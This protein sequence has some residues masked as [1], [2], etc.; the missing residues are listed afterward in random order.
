MADLTSRLSGL[1]PE[2]RALLERRLRAGAT[3]V[4]PTGAEPLAVIGIGCRFPGAVRDH[5]SLWQLLLDG[6]DAVSE[7]PRERWN[8]DEL[9]DA[10]PTASGRTNTRWGGFLNTKDNLES[11]DDQFFRISPREAERMDP[12]QRLL[13]ETSWEALEHAGLPPDAL[14]GQA[15]GVFV[16]IHS[17]S[18]DYY[19]RQASDLPPIDAYTSTGVAH[20]IVANR[21]S[22]I[23]DLRG[24][25]LAVDTACSSSLVAVH[26]ACQ[27]LRHRESDVALAGG[28]NLILTPEA[29]VAFSKLQMMAG[30]GRCK[31]FDKRADGFVRGE[32]CGVVVLKRLS[33]AQR[34]GDPV[35][36]VIRGSAVNQDGATNGLTAPNGLAQQAVIRDALKNAGVAPGTVSYIET[37]GTGTALGDPIEVEAISAVLEVETSP[38]P[39]VLG[40]LKTNIGHL[41]AAAGIAGLIK[42]VLCLK[43]RHIPRNL[44]FESINPHIRL[45][46]TRLRLPTENRSWDVPEGTPRLAGVSSFGFGGT[47]AHIVLEEAME[48]SVAPERAPVGPFV[49]PLSARTEQ[50]LNSSIEAWKTFLAAPERTG[51]SLADITYSASCRRTHHPLRRAVVGETRQEL[52]DALNGLAKTGPAPDDKN[53]GPVFVYSGQGPQ[54]PGMGQGLYETEPVFRTALDRCDAEFRRHATWSLLDEL[55]APDGKSRLHRTDIAQP[56]L[57]AVQMGLTELFRAWGIEPDAVVGHSIGEVAAAWASGAIGFEDAARLVVGRGRLMHAAHGQGRMLAVELPPDVLTGHL[58]ALPGRLVIAAINSPT[59][60]VVSGDHD[61]V[62][63]LEQRLAADGIR[64]KTVNADYAFHSHQVETAAEQ[65][66]TT[67]SDLTP[68]VPRVTLVSSVTG[69]PIKDAGCTSAY[70]ARNVRQPVRF[71][72]AIR[73][74]ISDGRRMF[75]EVGPHPVLTSMIAACGVTYADNDV[76]VV[77]TLRRGQVER[78]AALTALGRLYEIGGRVNWTNVQGSAR[79]VALPSYP[80]D[81]R[82]HWIEQPKPAASEPRGIDHSPSNDIYDVRW[83]VRGRLAS[84][85]ARQSPAYINDP[86]MIARRLGEWRRRFPETPASST[87]E[88]E[89]ISRLFAARALRALSGGHDDRIERTRLSEAV[90]LPRAVRLLARL[91]RTLESAG[92]MR[93]TSDGWQVSAPSD[94][95]VVLLQRLIATD[96]SSAPVARLLGHCGPRLADALAGTIEPLSLL[97]S[98]DPAVSAERIYTDS[99]FARSGNALVAQ[100]VA[101][102]VEHLPPE[103]AIRILEIGAGTGSTTAELIDL[104][105]E[106]RAEYIFTDVSSGFLQRARG[107]FS[108]QHP[109]RYA[110][111]DVE[112]SL[113]DQGFSPGQ[114]DI[115]VAANVLHTTADLRGT[116]AR[117]HRLLAPQGLLILLEGASPRGWV[118]LT[119]GLTEGWWKFTDTDRRRD[120]PLVSGQ[121]WCEA[122]AQ[123]GFSHCETVAVSNAPEHSLFEQSIV[124]ARAG[125]T[126]ERTATRPSPAAS[127]RDFASSTWCLFAD[128]TGVSSNL[129]RHLAQRGDRV[130]VVK[131]GA[132]FERIGDHTSIRFDDF[133]D[134]DALVT[135]LP[136]GADQLL[137]CVYLWPLDAEP[138]PADSNWDAAQSVACGGLINFIAALQRSGRSFNGGLWVVTRGAQAAQSGQISLSQTPL[139]GI[140]RGI[141]VERPELW[142]GLIDLDHAGSLDHV[143]TSMLE[144]F[145]APDGE[146]QIALRGSERFVPRLV[147][148]Q[149]QTVGRV[150]L[151]RD[152]SYFIT[153]G[154]G[155]LGLQLARWMAAAGAGWIVLG[156]RRGSAGAPSHVLETVRSIEKLGAV[157][158]ITTVDAGEMS[159]LRA[160]MDSFGRERPRLGG[161][162]H[163]AGVVETQAIES[164]P[165]DALSRVMRPKV[166]GAWNLHRLSQEHTPD[167]FVMFSSAA[168]VWGAAGMA[169]YAAANHFLDALARYRTGSGLPA[170]CLNWGWWEGGGTTQE[171]HD[172]YAQIGLESMPSVSAL[173]ALEAVLGSGRSH[174]TI[175]RVEWSRFSAVYQARRARPLLEY[176]NDVAD[177]SRRDDGAATVTSIDLIARLRNA[178]DHDKLPQLASH[179]RAE[180]ARV[181]GLPSGSRIED[182]EGFFELGMDSI[183]TVELRSRLQEGLGCHLP[184]TVA[185]EYPN[186]LALAG[187]I[188]GELG[189]QAAASAND[190]Q[191]ADSKMDELSGRSADE[192]AALLDQA[193]VDSLDVESRGER[194]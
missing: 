40:A 98:D 103:R 23:L 85:I 94:D 26:L 15:V 100:A 95:P 164:L 71:S 159:S 11:F 6:V 113:D 134:F 28:V 153:G 33:D 192:L 151:R 111:L 56:A 140:G 41:E 180:V 59:S 53:D 187:F 105:P 10:N 66:A 78:Y 22:Y 19:W 70:W 125:S 27:S 132:T 82:T 64:C 76:V 109:I 107:K 72:D 123:V 57:F 115:I 194:N 38:V 178:A 60:S 114:V 99:L 129:Q 36:A 150:N 44:H 179:V 190:S 173:A 7:I 126:A 142:G 182:A 122:L 86:A 108:G 104:L 157:V 133:S 51:I 91:A 165:L 21:V 152:R 149:P 17:L 52:I 138:I 110:T 189:L 46:G 42:A 79:A 45:E 191:A 176:I 35:L 166:T 127:G 128:E 170:T 88:L 63:A 102:A 168:S 144:E 163:A 119:F 30:N 146:D 101:A 184:V 29:T 154:T 135:G 43:H 54:W 97:F 92:W 148:V 24:P 181:L 75:L 93:P 160:V 65:L 158:D 73:T 1:S 143:V 136:L 141:S 67:I 89:R 124:L 25:S 48:V 131:N 55:R 188:A 130:I 193:I 16:G 32:G 49:L 171:Q 12:Q 84:S 20:S 5:A 13:L 112:R 3:S 147:R 9:Y 4:Q 90:T 185:F 121:G 61:A 145:E 18:T 96:A 74:L 58:R 47:N 68:S 31:T 118:D 8:A 80:W 34:D 161:I 137:R 139:W 186:V 172:Y 155:G 162:V 83:T 50:A 62:A 69:Q 87:T 39:C 177:R 175:A 14:A 2:K 169:H 77:P 156:S 117:V 106:D 120:Y 37:H 174:A 183:M 116:L 167:F 81:R